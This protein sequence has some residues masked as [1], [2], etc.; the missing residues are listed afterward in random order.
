MI[1]LLLEFYDIVQ[2]LG[3]IIM[4]ETSCTFS[5]KTIMFQEGF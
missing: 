5:N 2:M 3:I 1:K 4:F